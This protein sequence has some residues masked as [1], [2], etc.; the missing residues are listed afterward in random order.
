M[1]LADA[2]DALEADHELAEV[3]GGYFVSSFL[4]Y[5]RHEIERFVTDWEFRGS[6]YHL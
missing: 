4:A 6:A 3:L 1:R 2:L 5:K